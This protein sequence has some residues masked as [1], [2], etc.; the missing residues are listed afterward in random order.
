MLPLLRSRPKD[1]P[2]RFTSKKRALSSEAC[3]LC[4]PKDLNSQFSHRHTRHSRLCSGRAPSRFLGLLFVT[5]GLPLS[6]LGRGR[7]IHTFTLLPFYSYTFFRRIVNTR[8]SPRVFPGRRFSSQWTQ[9]G[10][11]FRTPILPLRS[12][13]HEPASGFLRPRRRPRPRRPKR[14]SLRLWPALH[15]L[16]SHGPRYS[17]LPCAAF[18]RR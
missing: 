11:T 5:L 8:A 15:P 14:R 7:R 4:G 10:G 18:R 13:G 12:P 9:R 6:P 17:S 16:R 1:S 3:G 2:V